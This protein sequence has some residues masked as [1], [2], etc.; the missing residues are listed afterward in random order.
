MTLGHAARIACDAPLASALTWRFRTNFL[1][2]SA[3]PQRLILRQT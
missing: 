3:H 2:E 1:A